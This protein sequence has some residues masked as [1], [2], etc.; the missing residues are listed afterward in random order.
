MGCDN[1][2]MLI[3]SHGD[4]VLPDS[5]IEVLRREGVVE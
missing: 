2:C 1:G 4:H 5:F 3:W